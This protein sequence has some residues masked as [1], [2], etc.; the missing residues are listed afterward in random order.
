MNSLYTAVVSILGLSRESTGPAGVVYLI[1][2]M[3]EA[4]ASSGAY[5]GNPFSALKSAIV[6]STGQS[7]GY[8]NEGVEQLLT[9]A[10][11]RFASR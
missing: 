9:S 3:G 4:N 8:H 5:V 7:Y 10:E 1:C 11:L 6:A 2:K